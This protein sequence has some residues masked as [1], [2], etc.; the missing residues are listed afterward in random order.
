M[1]STIP[2][3][4]RR[5]FHGRSIGAQPEAEGHGFKPSSMATTRASDV[6]IASRSVR[7]GSAM[8]DNNHPLQASN[9]SIASRWVDSRA[10]CAMPKCRASRTA[11][12]INKECDAART[13][14]SI[15]IR[16]KKSSPTRNPLSQP[17]NLDIAECS[18][19]SHGDIAV[20]ESSR[21]T[22]RVSPCNAVP[23]AVNVDVLNV[24]RAGARL[25]QDPHLHQA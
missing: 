22:L 14:C 11:L 25:F 21:A 7:C 19:Q 17:H 4:M 2:I 10:H 1:P 6:S 3:R 5:S 16:S 18:G 15:P 13:A 24:A 8:S 23:A 9:H 20:H 12:A